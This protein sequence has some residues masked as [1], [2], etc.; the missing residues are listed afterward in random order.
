M[1]TVL[2]QQHSLHHSTPP[3]S[4]LPS[5]LTV[6]RRPSPIPNKHIP[7]CPPGPAPST[8]SQPASPVARSDQ[9]SSLLYPPDER[10][11]IGRAPSP[12]VYAIEASK[13]AAAMDHQASQPLPDPSQMFPWLHGLHPDN[14]LQIGFFQSRKRHSRRSPKCWRGLTVVKLGGDLSRSRIK[15]AVSPNEVIAPSSRFLMAD[16][17]EGFSVRNFHIQTAKLAAMSD[18]VLYA[19]DDNSQAALVAL[20]DQFATAQH[21]WRLKMDPLQERPTYNTFI[22]ATPFS[23][24]EKEHPEIVAVD[25]K[26]QS[27]DRTMDFGHWERREMCNMSRASEI[28]ANVWLGSTPEF[29]PM[30]GAPLL[31]EETYDLFIE[32]TD[33]ANIP[34]PRY[35]AKLDRQLETGPQRM[36][37]PSSGSLVLP[38]GNTREV[39]DIVNTIRWIYYLAH[40]ETPAGEHDTDSDV[41]MA[42][43]SGKQRKILIHCGDGYTE[44]SLLAVAY[45]MFAEGVPAHEAW[46]RLHC[47]KKRNFFAYP[48]DV[49]F[50]CHIQERLLQE[51]PAAQAHATD[52][53]GT[54]YPN[55]FHHMDGSFPSRI[56]PY[57]Y[58]GN[59]THANNPELLWEL[60]IRRVLSIGEAVNWSDEDRATWGRDNLMYIDNVQDNGIDPLC[61]E[62]DRC[63]DFIEKGKREGT[64]TLV[65]CR[66][67]VSRSASICIAEVMA[68]KK[69]SFPRAYCY[70]RARRLNVIIQP[71]LRFVYE[72]LQ[73]EEHQLR[74]RNEPVKRE[75]EWQTVT[76]EI[77]L[78]NKPY[79]RS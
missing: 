56:L 68:C 34:G 17:Q 15:G 45:F 66:V 42:S 51:S 31:K 6:N 36:E 78:L 57:L 20:A 19:E 73:W 40:P 13:L 32:A 7:V 79:S 49:A 25:S 44:T 30:S 18:I 39:E 72:L 3:S 76:R 63:L 12:A 54:C 55:W 64:A 10:L 61:Q 21:A 53:A 28:S 24:L 69:L 58:L 11:R 9:P 1:A 60:G 8:P 29:I 27:T 43:S 37:F 41:A 5:T 46:L 74:K 59:L 71:H 77:A 62:Y 52:I 75:L 23:E 65:H 38:S 26:G 70:V 22:V 16:P 50:L 33:L 48:T 4:P 35:L 14:H 67:G 2:V 47:D